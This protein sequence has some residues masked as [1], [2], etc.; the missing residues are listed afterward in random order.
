M[1]IQE[2]FSL[3]NFNTLGIEVSAKYFVEVYSNDELKSTLSDP[4]FKEIPEINF[5]R[6]QQYPFYKKF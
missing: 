3:K 2:N 6:R 5:R 4:S 1:K